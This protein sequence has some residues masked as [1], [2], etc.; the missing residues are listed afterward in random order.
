MATLREAHI[1]PLDG[2]LFRRIDPVTPLLRPNMFAEP[3]ILEPEDG[4]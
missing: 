1:K 4:A 3:V 2:I